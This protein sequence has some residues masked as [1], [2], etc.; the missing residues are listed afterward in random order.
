MKMFQ[1]QARLPALVLMPLS[2]AFMAAAACS[3]GS[4]PAATTTPA[5]TPKGPTAAP[6]Y[7]D[8]PSPPP[9][10]LTR[11]PPTPALPSPTPLGAR[12]TTTSSAREAL[13]LNA[14]KSGDVEGVK[15]LLAEG[16]SVD[17]RDTTGGTALVG[18]AYTKQLEMAKVLVSAG[19]DVNVKDNSGQSAYLIATSEIGGDAAALQFLRLML[20]SG[21]DLG[22]LDSYNGTGLIRAADRGYVEIVKELL[23]AG[24]DVNHINRL[25]WTALLEA[26]IL[27]RGDANHT[28]V[29]RALVAGGADVNLA[30]GGGKTPLAH[31]RERGYPAIVAILEAAGGR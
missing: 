30:D 9:T 17:A 20:A 28:E 24:T 4:S 23:A 3:G 31:A 7:N 26:V 29:V 19:A 10:I 25:G 11:V 15:R 27:G 8:F 1:F 22:S 21:A 6:T 13:L 16:A 14:A 12:P 5:A 2:F 18:A